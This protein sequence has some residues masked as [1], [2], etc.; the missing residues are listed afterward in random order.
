MPQNF[1]VSNNN[2]NSKVTI[3]TN[4][5]NSTDTTKYKDQVKIENTRPITPLFRFEHSSRTIG[6]VNTSSRNNTPFRIANTSK[7]TAPYQRA[8]DFSPL[9]GNRLEKKPNKKYRHLGKISVKDLTKRFNQVIKEELTDKTTNQTN[10]FSLKKLDRPSKLPSEEVKRV[11]QIETALR[12]CN[13]EILDKINKGKSAEKFDEQIDNPFKTNKVIANLEG[14]AE[15]MEDSELGLSSRM[16]SPSLGQKSSKRHVLFMQILDIP[17]KN[18]GKKVGWIYNLLGDVS[19]LLKTVMVRN[20]KIRINF[21]QIAGRDQ[22]RKIL[23]D[24]EIELFLMATDGI[25]NQIA[26]QKKI[27]VRDIPLDISD[28]EVGTA[29]KKFGKEATRAVDQWSTLI[30]KDAN[31]T[32]HYLSNTLDQIKARSCFIPRTSRNYIRIGC[33]YIGFDSEASHHNATNKPLVIGDT[34]VHW[35][36]TDAK[37]NNANTSGSQKA[38]LQ[39][40]NKESQQKK[41]AD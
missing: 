6:S 29:M 32:A 8:A 23:A 34:L 39:V 7:R 41:E 25:V 11:V 27:L 36:P 38:G 24:V 19:Y 14:T 4:R 15:N 9:T 22:A 21:F 28:R 10:N 30:R 17:E 12:K 37:E 40:N 16:P 2:T 33:A 20:Q 31:C 3:V 5:S 1:K 26:G 13:P 18:M 35:V